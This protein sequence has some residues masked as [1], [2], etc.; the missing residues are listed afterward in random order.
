MFYEIEYDVPIDISLIEEEKSV[1]G[2]LELKQK[3][4]E[5]KFFPIP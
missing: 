4:H 5:V 1:N 2:K 3:W